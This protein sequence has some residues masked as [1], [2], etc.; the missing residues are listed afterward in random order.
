MTKRCPSKLRQV[1]CSIC[2]VTF[3]TRHSMGKYCSLEC[4]REGERGS[5]RSYSARN[6]TKRRELHRKIR[7]HDPQKQQDRHRVY[8]QSEAGR[9]A[10]KRNTKEQI[11]R[12]PEKYRARQ[13]VNKALK[14][15]DLIRKACRCG[16]TNNVHAHHHDYS[17]PLDIEWM[18][19][20]CHQAEHD[21]RDDP[22]SDHVV[23]CRQFGR[24][25]EKISR[26]SKILDD[27]LAENDE[28]NSPLRRYTIES[29]NREAADRWPEP[30]V[31][32]RE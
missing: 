27:L 4:R 8:N 5:W 25:I 11:R 20:P 7:Q 23:L 26:M 31:G 30:T 28:R 32:P 2:E 18:C 21:P 16:S 24:A 13:E 9:A 6:K 12:W 17:K 22:D 19:R 29:L 15:G 14:R 3:Q 10:S 1:K